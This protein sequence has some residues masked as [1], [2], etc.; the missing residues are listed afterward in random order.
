VM[1]VLQF[2]LNKWALL[3]MSILLFV[4]FGFFTVSAKRMEINRRRRAS[5]A[6]R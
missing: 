4:L 2:G 5:L 3:P 6:M 1:T